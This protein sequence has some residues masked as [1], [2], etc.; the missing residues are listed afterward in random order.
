MKA[1]NF[2]ESN[3][4]IN[5]VCR[6]QSLPGSTG[7]SGEGGATGSVLEDAALRLHVEE[8]MNSAP[9]PALE[10]D[11]VSFG[12]GKGAVLADLSLGLREE[13]SFPCWGRAG[14]ARAR[15]CACWPGWRFR[16]ATIRHVENR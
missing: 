9:Q 13:N 11:S 7:E 16:N 14:Q 2:V 15:C 12:Y 4:D 3:A 6:R 1:S 8:L 5:T 10:L